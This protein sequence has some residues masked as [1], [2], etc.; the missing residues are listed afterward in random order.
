MPLGSANLSSGES[1]VL[2]DWQREATAWCYFLRWGESRTAHALLTANDDVFAAAG[3]KCGDEV[4]AVRFITKRFVMRLGEEA[5][6]PPIAQAQIVGGVDFARGISVA[7]GARGGVD[8]DSDL[9]L[10][11]GEVVIA[12]ADDAVV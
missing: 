7:S 12:H 11:V 5:Q 3:Q 8:L 10:G 2:A 1:G 4:V 6:S 9:G